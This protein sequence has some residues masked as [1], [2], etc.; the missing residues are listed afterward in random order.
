MIL[1]VMLATLATVAS[2]F[3]TV[4]VVLA[5]GRGGASVVAVWL[6]TAALWLSVAF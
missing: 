1:A 4:I 5:G 2:L 6:L 3:W